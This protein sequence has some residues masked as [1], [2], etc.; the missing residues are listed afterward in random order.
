MCKFVCT[1]GEWMEVPSRRKQKAKKEM[2]D[3]QENRTRN[4]RSDQLQEVVII[5]SVYEH[6][7]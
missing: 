3:L 5:Q 6:L 7:L 4:E 1:D 2:A